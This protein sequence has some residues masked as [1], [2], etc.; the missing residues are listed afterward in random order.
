MIMT[1][2]PPPPPPPF[3][4]SSSS[5][6]VVEIMVTSIEGLNN[7]TSFFNPKIKPFITITKLPTSTVNPTTTTTPTSDHVFRV[8]VDHTFF[9]DTYSCIYLELFTKRRIVGPAQLGWCMIPASDIGLLSPGSVRYLSYR[10]RAKDGSRG[11]AV[12]NISVRLE[13]NVR[14]MS[15]SVSRSMDTCHAVIGIPVTAVRGI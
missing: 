4:S 8:P 13:G 9:H 5:A 14:W 10:L 6:T 7:Y 11:Q 12:I 1:M 3:S 15:T 2:P